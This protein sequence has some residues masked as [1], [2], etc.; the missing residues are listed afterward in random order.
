[1][2]DGTPHKKPPGRPR[3]ASSDRAILDAARRLLAAGSLS[4]LTMEAV[5]SEA[6]VAKTTLYRRWRSK[7]SLALSVLGE[8]AADQIPVPDL[9]D[10]R[11]ELVHAVLDTA[12]TMTGTIAGK[13]IRGLI[14]ALADDEQLA[15]EFRNTLVALRRREM[16]RVVER[17]LA[18]GDLRA[19]PQL[20]LIG[21]LLIGPLFW[22]LLMTGDPLD[23]DFAE[24]LVD[25]VLL[26]LAVE[27]HVPRAP[28]R[29]GVGSR[30]P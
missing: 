24:T 14:P 30:T 16:A 4:G 3:S 8:M 19:G 12:R 7:E 10:T 28:A 1:V 27:R 9:G 13:T 26:G 22:R 18:R 2:T 15:A 23:E 17:G 29:R 20:A 5:A 21:E 11:A 25:G 6:K